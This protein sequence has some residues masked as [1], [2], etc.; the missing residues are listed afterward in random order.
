MKVAFVTF[1]TMYVKAENGMHPGANDARALL[2]QGIPAVLTRKSP[3]E[4][5]WCRA[6]K[7]VADK[8]DGAVVHV[9]H[10]IFGFILEELARYQ[11]K[12]VVLVSC[13]CRTE[14]KEEAFKKYGLEGVRVVACKHGGGREMAR[15]YRKF[16]RTGCLE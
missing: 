1:G 7:S 6:F 8:L 2:V 14:A 9:G 13:E 5:S 15:L 12:N 10:H 3:K 11:K 16:L 4:D